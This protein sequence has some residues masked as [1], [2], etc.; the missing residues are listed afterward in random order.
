MSGAQAAQVIKRGSQSAAHKRLEVPQGLVSIEE[1]TVNHQV[2]MSADH[3]SIRPTLAADGARPAHERRVRRGAVRDDQRVYALLDLDETLVDKSQAFAQWAAHL[4][5]AQALDAQAL[6]WLIDTDKAIKPRGPFFAEVTRRWPGLGNAQ[7]LWDDYAQTMPRLV[8][9]FPGVVGVLGELRDV[10]YRLVVVTNGRRDNQEAKLRATGL[11]EL[12]DDWIISEVVGHRKPGAE[13]Y[14]AALGAVGCA[15]PR[16]CWMV[17]D[18]P[19]L[20][21]IPAAMLGLR[22][23]WVSHG[24]SWSQTGTRPDVTADDPAQA[25]AALL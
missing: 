16:A 21:V 1:D 3:P 20:D 22:T 15:D 11:A 6:S 7:D 23:V 4:V 12:V 24:R 14:A 10:G 9:V 5:D 25:L 17:G 13:I 2:M 8:A 18:D 19:D